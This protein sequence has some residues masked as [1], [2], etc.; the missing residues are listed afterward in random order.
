MT[1]A[2]RAL[3]LLAVAAM[4]CAGPLGRAEQ[5][6]DEGR[7][8]DAVSD[9]RRLEPEVPEWS[10]KRQARYA[11]TRGLTHLACGDSRQALRWLA[12][13]KRRFEADPSLLDDKE[14]GRLLSAW[15][16]MGL[17]PNEGAI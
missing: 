5:A 12:D 4:G 8:P 6:F 11:L 14:R 9:L 13:A 15:R 2:G 10:P 17:M 3:L 16:T 7:Y 1:R